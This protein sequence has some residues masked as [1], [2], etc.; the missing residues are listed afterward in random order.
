VFLFSI[1]SKLPFYR[2]SRP[3]WYVLG[4]TVTAFAL[5]ILLPYTV[6]GQTVFHF[7]PPMAAHMGIILGLVGAYFLC[8]ELVKNVYYRSNLG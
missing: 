8:S 2:A 5:T 7:T 6:I 1:R 3:S 4:L